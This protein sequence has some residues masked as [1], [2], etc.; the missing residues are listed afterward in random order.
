LRIPQARGDLP[1]GGCR[2]ALKTTFNKAVRLLGK[3]PL[4]AID[5]KDV[6][7]VFLASFVLKVS[8]LRGLQA[9]FWRLAGKRS[10][11]NRPDDVLK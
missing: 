11:F 2:R 3:Q 10:R 8:I 7:M 5:E 6:V 4:D 1:G 9:V